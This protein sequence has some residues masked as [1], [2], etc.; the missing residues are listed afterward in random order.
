M[1]FCCW[2][3]CLLSA[4]S[5]GSGIKS[6]ELQCS[7]SEQILEGW[8]L[9]FTYLTALSSCFPC[10]ILWPIL[11]SIT[12]TGTFLSWG[13][14]GACLN[15]SSSPVSVLHCAECCTPDIWL[16]M[17]CRISR[18]GAFLSRAPTFKVHRW[19][20]KSLAVRSWSVW[21]CSGSLR[22][23]PA[24]IPLHCLPANPDTCLC[25]VLLGWAS[26]ALQ[27]SNPPSLV[28]AEIKSC[29]LFL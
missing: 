19:N 18:P 23:L 3:W 14:P 28:G 7:C 21:G 29:C 6:E 20:S 8:L 26:S 16:P 1:K 11:L 13:I 4:P 17:G 25:S 24:A 9:L 22:T 15:S 10:F 2:P 27:G 5:G 12:A